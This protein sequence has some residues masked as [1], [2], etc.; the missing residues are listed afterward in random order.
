MTVAEY[1][2]SADPFAQWKQPDHL[3]DKPSFKSRHL[4]R[5][6]STAGVAHLSW[7]DVDE[8]FSELTQEI[9]TLASRMCSQL[10]P[11]DEY[12]RMKAKKARWGAVHQALNQRRA[13][14][15]K[16][17]K[18][19]QTLERKLPELFVDIAKEELP[20]EL[21]ARLMEGAKEREAECLA[22]LATM[23]NVVP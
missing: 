9:Q 21:F 4:G 14:R 19:R 11:K 7:E 6:V 20:S 17:E 12:R 22:E 16:T 10:W 8:L 23:E 15:A 18:K 3:S 1:R 2:P 13:V 5:T